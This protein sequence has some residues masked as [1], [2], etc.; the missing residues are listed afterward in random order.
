M[1]AEVPPIASATS[2]NWIV[3]RSAVARAVSAS[4]SSTSAFTTADES[5]DARALD[6]G[7]LARAR[8][9]RAPAGSSPIRRP[10]GR[11]AG[12]FPGCGGRRAGG[13]GRP[14][15]GSPPRLELADVACR[16]RAVTAGAAAASLVRE[17]REA[18][19]A[20]PQAARVVDGR[21]AALQAPGDDQREA[22]R[23]QGDQQEEDLDADELGRQ[24]LGRTQRGRHGKGPEC[25]AGRRGRDRMRNR[26]VSGAD[27][28]KAA[29]SP[30]ATTASNRLAVALELLRADAADRASASRSG[31]AARAI[32][33]SVLSW[34]IT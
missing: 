13:P 21:G 1:S 9:A 31:G 27:P 33:T 25:G 28:G 11:T 2:A 23:H 5:L 15:A 18:V 16:S 14:P 3:R 4:I 10:A 32:S 34:K 20:H 19:G 29:A 12:R 24:F 8:R 17:V 22:D 7:R 26:A 6:G 30:P